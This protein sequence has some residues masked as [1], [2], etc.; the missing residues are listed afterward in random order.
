MDDINAGAGIAFGIIFLIFFNF[1]L[2]P[3]LYSIII[4]IYNSMREAMSIT[5]KAITAI[6]SE[7]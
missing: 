5:T 1:I 6:E 7:K 4:V 3:Y 2:I